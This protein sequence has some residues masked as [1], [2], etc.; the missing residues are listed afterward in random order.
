MGVIQDSR[1]FEAPSAEGVKLKPLDCRGDEGQHD[2]LGYRCANFPLDGCLGWVC[3]RCANKQQAKLYTETC[4]M[5]SLAEKHGSSMKLALAEIAR[6]HPANIKSGKVVCAATN[7]GA[8]ECRRCIHKTCGYEHCDKGKGGKATFFT[9]S[10]REAHCS[11]ICRAAAIRES[12]RASKERA[13]AE[14]A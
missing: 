12:K 14:A 1:L 11:D 2:K 8:E 3:K 5:C 10:R 9:H 13:R 4:N 7:K 6:L